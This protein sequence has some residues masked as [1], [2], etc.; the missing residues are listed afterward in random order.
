MKVSLSSTHGTF[1]YPVFKRHSF[2]VIVKDM[3]TLTWNLWCDFKIKMT[4]HWLTSNYNYQPLTS[5][6]P[7]KI[8]TYPLRRSK[9]IDHYK[10]L[11]FVD[12]KGG[13]WSIASTRTPRV[14]RSC[15]LPWTGHPKNKRWK[16]DHLLSQAW[17]LQ[18]RERRDQTLPP[19]HAKNLHFI[20]M[21]PVNI[22]L[23]P[24]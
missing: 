24:N 13:R 2:V 14:V 3:H 22:N 19:P 23:V 20:L 12:R 4:G 1:L 18:L 7:V 17:S 11:Y 8:L 10:R 9:D 15:F 21:I 16:T 6:W 5:N